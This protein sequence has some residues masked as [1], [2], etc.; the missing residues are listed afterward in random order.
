MKKDGFILQT[1]KKNPGA[2]SEKISRFAE[3]E[4]FLGFEIDIGPFILKPLF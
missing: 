4:K 3:P 1:R 2:K